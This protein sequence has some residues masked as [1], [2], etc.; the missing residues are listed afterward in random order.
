MNNAAE[1]DELAKVIGKALGDVTG[2]YDTSDDEDRGL[3]DA[4]LAAGYTKDPR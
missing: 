3:A 1:R 2:I 4:I